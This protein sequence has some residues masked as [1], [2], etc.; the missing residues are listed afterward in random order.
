MNTYE[1]KEKIN[2][3]ETINHIN[4]IESKINELNLLEKELFKKLNID[5]GE[6]NV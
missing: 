5:G 1:E 3:Q 2:I 4:D 6:S